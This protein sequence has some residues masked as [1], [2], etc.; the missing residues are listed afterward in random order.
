MMRAQCPNCW[1]KGSHYVHV[2]VPDRIHYVGET[3]TSM[4]IYILVH[5]RLRALKYGYEIGA[6]LR[7]LRA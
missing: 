6:V 7:T 1:K 5:S 3:C 2:D 4:Q